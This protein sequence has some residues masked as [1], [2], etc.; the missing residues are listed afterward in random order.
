MH[1]VLT[2]DDCE[3]VNILWQLGKIFFSRNIRPFSNKYGLKHRS[4]D[5]IVLY[6]FTITGSLTS[7]GDIYCR[8]CL[9]CRRWQF[10][11][12][13]VA[14]IIAHINHVN[15]NC[16]RRQDVSIL[17]FS[18]AKRATIYAILPS[19]LKQNLFRLRKSQ[20]F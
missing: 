1:P 18:Q 4:M 12:L 10:M 19:N 8:L 14:R 5:K 13:F 16:E 6:N 2:V 9:Y 15:I 17:T 11:P 20:W 7:C 3:I